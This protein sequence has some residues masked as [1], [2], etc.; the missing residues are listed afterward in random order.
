[1]PCRSVNP[2]GF[3]RLPT[4]TSDADAQD[5]L[6]RLAICSRSEH[7]YEL[8]QGVI[9]F[10]DKLWIGA[11]TVLQTKPVNAFHA[12]VVGGHSARR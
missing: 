9:R 5:L 10:H 6:Q 8:H 3:R 1:M 11:N 4:C 7:G 12:S 2:N